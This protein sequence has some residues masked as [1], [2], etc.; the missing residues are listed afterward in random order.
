MQK[1]SLRA[2][3]LLIWSSELPHCNYP[4]DSNRFRKCQYVKMFGAPENPR[5]LSSRRAFMTESMGSSKAEMTKLGGKL[6]G[7]EDW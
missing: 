7:F 4:N 1:I 3:S 5:G 2:G 6:L